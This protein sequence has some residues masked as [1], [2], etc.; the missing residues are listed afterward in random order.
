MSPHTN[1]PFRRA[2]LVGK[3]PNAG[4]AAQGESRALLADAL[5]VNARLRPDIIVLDEAQRIK[6]WASKTAQAVKRLRSRHAFG[7]TGT[8]IESV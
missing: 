5:D 3:F 1:P 2:A 8:P 6:N 7:P 4:L